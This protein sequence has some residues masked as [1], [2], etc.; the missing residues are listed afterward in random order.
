V[1]DGNLHRGKPMIARSVGF[2]V[3]HFGSP[4]QRQLSLGLKHALGLD[5]VAA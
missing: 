1:S 2:A 5:R 3:K 4:R